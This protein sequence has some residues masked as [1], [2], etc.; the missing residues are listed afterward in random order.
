MGYQY[1]VDIAGTEYGMHDIKSAK[2]TQPL[3]DKLSVGNACSAEFSIVFWQKS[4]I[5]R[6]AKIIP[7]CRANEEEEWYQIGIFYIDT[8]QKEGDTLNVFA[9]DTMIKAEQEWVPRQELNFPM[10][11]KT[12]SAEIASIMGT[13]LD[14]RCSFNEK[15][16]IDYPANEYTLRDVLRYI[17]GANGG[18]WIVTNEGK[19]LL[20]PLFGYTE[21][22]TNY[23]VTE[24][25]NPITL[26]GTRLLV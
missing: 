1:K 13:T 8:R 4:D 15:Y 21:Y 14:G 6:A 5:P 20:V 24:Y 16:T 17:A 26:G 18:N 7:Y 2:V 12:A 23:L 9:Y 3:F 11:M 10:S 19:L 25:G 22:E